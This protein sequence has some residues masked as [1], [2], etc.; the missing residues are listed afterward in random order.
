MNTN[1]GGR[2]RIYTTG[3]E[4]KKAH[5]RD[6]PKCYYAKKGIPLTAEQIEQQCN[7]KQ[8][9]RQLREKIKLKK[10]NKKTSHGKNS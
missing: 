7:I 10:P 6:S 9:R 1:K 3:M 5:A 8:K 2:P 4:E